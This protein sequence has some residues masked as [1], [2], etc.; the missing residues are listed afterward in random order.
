M[1]E[2]LLDSAKAFSFFKEK[3]SQVNALS[4]AVLE[5]LQIKKGSFYAFLPENINNDKVHDF[6]AGGKTSSLRREVSFKLSR[7]IN[8]NPLLSCV[9]D[10]FNSDLNSVSNNDL[11][12]SC[13]LH[14]RNEIYYQ[15]HFGSN[16]KI[17]LKCL[18]Y[19]STIWHS[20]CVVFKGV[21]NVNKEIT[22]S[23]VQIICRNAIFIM[24][25]AYDSESYICWCD[26]EGSALLN[27][28]TEIQ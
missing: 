13:G 16:Q 18:N 5:L 27:T 2:Y 9:F 25:E 11:Y 20:L 12:Q 26:S 19:S 10:D 17:V 15:I 7:I 22:D 4:N 24:I 14:Y 3:L 6:N 8:S 23:Q 1:K 21:F 28:S